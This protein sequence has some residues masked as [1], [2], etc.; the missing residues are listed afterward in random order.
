V[1][2]EILP[3]IS[4]AG[5]QTDQVKALSERTRAVMVQHHDRLFR[6]I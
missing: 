6:V 5:L 4:T 1:I 3:P 2:V